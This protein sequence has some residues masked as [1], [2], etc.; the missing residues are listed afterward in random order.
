MFCSGAALGVVLPAQPWGAPRHREWGSTSS[1]A[2]QRHCAKWK[3]FASYWCKAQEGKTGTRFHLS[4]CL[5]PSCCLLF[6]IFSF[7]V[8]NLSRFLALAS[9]RESSLHGWLLQDAKHIAAFGLV[10]NRFCLLKLK[11]QLSAETINTK[12]SPHSV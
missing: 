7:T 6:K 11:G 9:I 4:A 2:Q 12:A 1:S 10:S 3:Q 5:K 8:R